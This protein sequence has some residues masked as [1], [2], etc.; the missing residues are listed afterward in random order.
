MTMSRTPKLSIDQRASLMKDYHNGMTGDEMADKYGV[1]RATVTNYIARDATKI[2]KK[3]QVVS[4]PISRDEA[5]RQL[6]VLAAV[7]DVSPEIIAELRISHVLA[8]HPDILMALVYGQSAAQAKS[9]EVV[10]TAKAVGG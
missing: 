10:G 6:A 1:S 3:K 2:E 5:K 4:A 9:P 8:R 7:A